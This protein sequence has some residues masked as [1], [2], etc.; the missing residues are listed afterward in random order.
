MGGSSTIWR[1]HCDELCN[2]LN[3]RF[4]FLNSSYELDRDSREDWQF[5]DLVK[6]PIDD[7]LLLHDNMF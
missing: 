4:L 7:L 2:L 5:L 6:S 1:Q 3:I